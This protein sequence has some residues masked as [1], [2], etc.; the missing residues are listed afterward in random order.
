MARDQKDLQKRPADTPVE[1]ERIE[2]RATF[3]PPVDIVETNAA[4]IVTADMPGVP[5]DAI[6]IQFEQGV[7]TLRGKVPPEK[8]QGGEYLVR[9]YGVGDYERCFSVSDEI[10]AEKIEAAYAAGVLTL[11][12]PKAEKVKPR[13]IQ[14]N[15]A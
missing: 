14:L 13:K 15:I 12:L 9:E 10:D 6:D 8:D 1:A 11:T 2:S 7:L 5:K 3:V 4:I